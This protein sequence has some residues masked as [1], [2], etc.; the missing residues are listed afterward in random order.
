MKKLI[1]CFAVV[2]YVL[3]SLGFA[4]EESVFRNVIVSGSNGSY[5]IHGEVLTSQKYFFYS[6]E[7][8][9]NQLLSE[10]KVKASANAGKLAQF[11]IH[12][13]I[14]ISELPKNATLILHLYEKS[15][16]GQIIHSYPVVLEVFN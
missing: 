13:D 6:V 2:F 14:P 4:K 9:H 3:P 7:D 8:G 10:T 1:L 11:S 12:V 15:T 16:S 5:E